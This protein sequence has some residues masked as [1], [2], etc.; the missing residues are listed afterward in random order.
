MKDIHKC[1]ICGYIYNA[2]FGDPIA[3]VREGTPFKD[4]PASWTCP[5]CGATVEEFEPVD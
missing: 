2:E 5:L 1:T 3:G 4:I